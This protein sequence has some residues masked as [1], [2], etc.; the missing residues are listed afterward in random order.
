MDKA[1]ETLRGI[2]TARPRTPALHPRQCAK[3]SADLPEPLARARSIAW[4]SRR[5][6]EPQTRVR[7]PA[8]PYS[9]TGSRILPGE[10]APS[11]RVNSSSLLSGAG[12]RSALGESGG[13]GCRPPGPSSPA[14]A[15]AG[16][17]GPVSRPLGSSGRRCREVRSY[18][19]GCARP[20]GARGDELSSPRGSRTRRLVR[21]SSGPIG[22]A[23]SQCGGVL[24][25]LGELSSRPSLGPPR[26]R[27]VCLGHA[28]GRARTG[29]H[30]APK[31][32]DGCGVSRN[33]ALRASEGPTP[34]PTAWALRG[35]LP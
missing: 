8:G 26:A 35:S 30:P 25:L 29:R 6:P 11:Q 31:A 15:P 20:G 22:A 5:P 10:K 3:L 34:L 12:D 9:S 19:R 32:G 14:A 24:P 21:Q 33:G 13:E 17:P 1:G 23:I 2:R 28:A 7:I 27:R 4:I 18:S 16:R